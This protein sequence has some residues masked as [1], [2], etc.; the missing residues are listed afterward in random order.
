MMFKRIGKFIGE[1]IFS[2]L[3]DNEC[4]CENGECHCGG[5]IQS[6]EEMIKNW[7]PIARYCIR[8]GG[9]D[10]WCDDIKPNPILG[11]DLM[12]TQMVEGEE[13]PV[14]CTIYDVGITMVDYQTPMTPE[15]FTHIKKQSL[16]YVMAELQQAKI[17]EDAAQAKMKT[18]PPEDVNFAS[19][20]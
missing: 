1:W 8:S 9:M 4:D 3:N 5:G 20:G 16:D 11:W 7:K 6:E 19:Y 17:K 12:W 18:K 15:V 14:T 13:K 2:S 10:Y